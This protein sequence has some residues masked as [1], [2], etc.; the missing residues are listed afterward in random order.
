[1]FE[2]L[3]IWDVSGVEG[4]THSLIW[5]ETGGMTFLI[6]LFFI[7]LCT[8]DEKERTLKLSDSNVVMTK[9]A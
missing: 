5:F 3:K 7:H 6:I 4:V 8:Q 2:A 1:M 9:V